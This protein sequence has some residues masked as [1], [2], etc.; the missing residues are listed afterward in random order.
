MTD[1]F[2]PRLGR[3][4]DRA[5]RGDQQ[6]AKQLKKAAARLGRKSGKARFSGAGIGRGGASARSIEMRTQRL[7]RFRMRR[8]IVKTHV[9][10]SPRGGGAGA[11]KAH[12]G[13]IQRDGVER[14]G[15]G[16]QI[17]TRDGVE[18]D[19]NA[20]VERCEGDRHQFR[21]IVS[22]EDAGLLGDLKD[23][24]RAL[25]AQMESDLGTRLDWLAVDHH[26]TGNPHTHIVIR[27]KDADGKDLI[28]SPEYIKQGLASRAQD[29]VTE[30]LGPRRDLEIAQAQ[31]REVALERFTGRDRSILAQASGGSVCINEGHEPRGRFE[32]A[33]LR[34]RLRHLE[35]LGLAEPAGMNAWALKPDWE[36]TLKALGQRG[37]I[38][39]ALAAKNRDSAP[40]QNLR[41]F[42]P[43]TLEQ[44][45]LLGSVVASVPEDELRDRRSL[46]V[47]D[48]HGTRWIVDIGLR[49]PGT[50]PPDGAVVEIAS[51]SPRLREI[52]ASILSIAER[53]G[54]R[55]S[56]ALHIDADP[57][58]TPAWRQGH[59]RRLEALRRVGILA[60]TDDGVWHV[61][62]DFAGRAVDYDTE[63]TGRIEVQVRSWLPLMEQ[64][65]HAGLTWL[66]AA[67]AG[68]PG[69][70]LAKVRQAR[71]AFFREKGWLE[72]GEREAGEVLR[73]RLRVMELRRASGTLASITGRAAVELGPGDRFEG[74]F[75]KAIDLG[76]GRIAV[77]G[78]AKEFALVPWRPE[79][80]R[81]RGRDMAFRR[82]AAGVSWT[83]GIERGLEQ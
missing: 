44:E 41:R 14:D 75:E 39:K 56:G 3:I 21:L 63:R 29:I 37:D 32:E 34:A 50:I 38:L 43:G 13:Y 25:L 16:G 74:R 7:P 77:V 78:N 62:K 28:I 17:Y 35:V 11:L 6:F 15:S 36:T 83:I 2:E 59:L 4:G 61:P 40:D 18:P 12:L 58:A 64:T 65:R 70:R 72:H 8:V 24:T 76:Q 57:T 66:D 1:E 81:H 9:S 52:D 60:R 55:Y 19:A 71:L 45:R 42:E 51:R 79:M 73:D 82:T 30:R 48:F 47:E 27:G 69:D 67:G 49:E 5:R 80:E 26:N 23:T 31:Q 22:A 53:S 33:L 54:G 10:R 20:F 68:V 46:V